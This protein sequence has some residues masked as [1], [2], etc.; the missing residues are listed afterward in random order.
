V[1]KGFQ[2]RGKD[3][4][5]AII[6]RWMN[7][8]WSGLNEPAGAVAGGLSKKSST[9]HA[10]T[11][12]DGGSDPIRLA[13]NSLEGLASAAQITVLEGLVTGDTEIDKI[14]FNLTAGVDVG[15]GELAWNADSG[16]TDMGRPDGGSTQLGQELVLAERPRNK[17]GEQ[18]DNGLAVYLSGATDGIPEVMLAN[19]AILS[20]RNTIAICTNDVAEDARGAYTTMGVVRDFDTTFGEVNDVVYLD[21]IDGQLT[22]TPPTIPNWIIRVGTILV[23]HATEGMLD[24]NIRNGRGEDLAGFF[25][26]TFREGFDA[27]VTSDGATITMTLERGGT[28][29]LTM[30]FSTGEF[31]LDCTDPICSIELSAGT[32]TVPQENFV[33]VPIS[34]KALTNSETQWP[35]E[36]HIK[37]SYFLVQTAAYVAADG[38]LVNQNWND[39]LYHNSLGHLAHITERIRRD[40]AL[41]FSGIAGEGGDDYT[42]SSAGVVTVQTGAGV[43]Y[44]MHQQIIAAKNTAVAGDIHVINHD[45]T[46]YFQTQ[47]LYDVVDD[48]A[49]GTL[50]NKY[51]NITLIEVANKGGEYAPL[52]VN[53]PNGTYN[54]L[55]GAVTDSSGYD[56]FSIPRAFSK[57]SSTGFLVARLTFRK[58]GG[59]W[60][61][62]ST[63]DLRGITPTTASGGAVGGTVSEFSDSLFRI[64]D[65]TDSTKSIAFEAST[66]STGETRTITMP[67]RDV[68]LGEG[69]MTRARL[70]FGA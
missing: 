35:T 63:V 48:A 46:P 65:N 2:Y 36:E 49:G 23:K 69:D 34:T 20:A 28:G 21:I 41:W 27:L 18:I 40:G 37:V 4:D 70:W 24:V 62:Y 1:G 44:Q 7:E 56:E 3:T 42:T 52:L 12:Y 39:P 58:T 30:Q 47:N 57:E 67:D 55:A 15:V 45:T 26:G 54:T 51:F 61:Y 10:S 19:A 59:S 33:Y 43:V 68:T 9:T 11:H 60:V 25:S 22:V 29:D 5:A 17:Q 38:A 31:T 13:T 64:N 8:T 14:N 32:A 53:L 6:E 50:N 16:T 66:V